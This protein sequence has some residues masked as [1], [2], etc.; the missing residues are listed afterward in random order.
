MENSFV[1]LN[2]LPDEIL[3]LI[4]KKLNID[5]IFYSLSGVNTRLNTLMHDTIFTSHVKLMRYCSN[6]FINPLSETI[7]DRFCTEILPTI[8]HKIQWLDVESTCME[9][10]LHCKAYPNLYRLGL[11]NL[12]KENAEHLFKSKIFYFNCLRFLNGLIGI[13]LIRSVGTLMIIN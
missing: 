4:L 13:E 7:L 9:R 11:Y 12:E 8:H 5:Q 6:N 1:Q 10:V 3:M 2:D